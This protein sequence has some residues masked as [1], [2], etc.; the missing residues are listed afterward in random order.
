MWN[1]GLFVYELSELSECDGDF[2]GQQLKTIKD[3]CD[4]LFK[5]TIKDN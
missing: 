4:E 3:N 1:Y 2:W 5:S